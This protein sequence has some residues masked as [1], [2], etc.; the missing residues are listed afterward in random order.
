[1]RHL[2]SSWRYVRY[3]SQFG[4]TGYGA[5]S[6]VALAL[7]SGC[8]AP[9]PKPPV[10]PAIQP[11]APTEDDRFRISAALAPLLRASGVWRGPED[12]CAVGLG[13]LPM[14]HI[15]LGVA[16]HPTCRFSLLVTE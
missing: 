14:K 1:M 11:R 12:G 3:I 13:I 9:Q 5:A 8:A 4:A 15:N 7:L 2:A 16:P 6:L 10:R